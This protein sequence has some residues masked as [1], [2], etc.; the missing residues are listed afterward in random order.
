ML[1]TQQCY[2]LKRRHLDQNENNP[3]TSQTGFHL[4]THSPL[5]DMFEISGG[6]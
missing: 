5:N 6:P 2:Q 4:N 1:H 3:P